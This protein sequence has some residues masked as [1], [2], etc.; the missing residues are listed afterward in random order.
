MWN[1]WLARVTNHA[2]DHEVARRAGITHTTIGRWRKSGRAPAEGII[3]IARA[4]RA[5]PIDGMVAAG[6]LTEADLMNGGL[7]NAVRHAP[8]AFLTDELHERAVSGKFDGE[9]PELRRM[10]RSWHP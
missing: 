9:F 3:T 8:T 7:R 6:L 2:S 1:Q 4:F 5:D 10:F